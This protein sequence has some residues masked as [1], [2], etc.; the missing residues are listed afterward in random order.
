MLGVAREVAALTG[1]KLKVVSS[2]LRVKKLLITKNQQLITL[3]IQDPK[4]C[5]RMYAALIENIKIT[6][7]PKW[8]QERLTA[9]GVK[10]INNV[11]DIT[12]YVM[13]ELGQP[14]HAFDADK[15]VGPTIQVRY[16]TQGE[17]MITLDN[18]ERELTSD[19]L[20]LADEKGPIDIAGIQGG[21]HTAVQSSTT[22][23]ILT[24]SQFNP[25]IIRRTARRMRFT[26][27]ASVRFERGL[28]QMVAEMALA[29]AVELFK[30]FAEGHVTATTS[31]IKDRIVPVKVTVDP[32]WIRQTLGAPTLPLPKMKS[33][34]QSLGFKVGGTA[35][36]WTISVPSWRHDIQISEDI[37]EE[38]GRILDYNTLPITA[39][40]GRIAA[41][42]KNELYMFKERLRDLMITAG[43]DEVKLYSFYGPQELKGFDL[44]G[45]PHYGLVNPLNPDQAMMRQSLLSRLVQAAVKNLP[46]YDT[47]ALFEL[48]MTFVPSSSVLPKQDMCLCALTIGKDSLLRMLGVLHMIREALGIDRTRLLIQEKDAAHT[49]MIDSKVVGRIDAVKQEILAPYDVK[50]PMAFLTLFPEVLLTLRTARYFKPFSLYP[51]VQRDISFVIQKDVPYATIHDLIAHAS[52]LIQ[53]V[54]LFDTFEDAKRFGADAWSMALRITFQHAERTLTSE[55]V[56]GVLNGI[57]ATLQ[58][59]YKANI[60]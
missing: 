50:T 15:L 27:D 39:L 1:N 52:P 12:N 45:K 35:K 53:E 47:M 16:A 17:K 42:P 4:L 9:C 25:A 24:A 20:V 26:T 43:F 21:L 32:E 6:P 8:M 60:R 23:I 2:E 33:I 7:S 51:A 3:H 38:I 49:I 46:T 57:K 10:A 44:E 19:T 54:R 11:V 30:K 58:S 22:R 34:L 29:R 14:L 55:E 31:F 56:E 18:K 41:P 5:P 36:R 48:G 37:L 28:D 13:L 40:Q 59:Q